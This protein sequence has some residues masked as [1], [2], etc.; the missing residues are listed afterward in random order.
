MTEMGILSGVNPTNYMIGQKLIEQNFSDQNKI[1]LSNHINNHPDQKKLACNNNQGY[2][3]SCANSFPLNSPSYIKHQQRTI[4]GLPGIEKPSKSRDIR[5]IN[6]EETFSN[7]IAANDPIS[8]QLLDINERPISDFFHNNMVPFYGAKLRQNMA[9]TGVASGSYT[10]GSNVP[11]NKTGINSGFDYSTPYKS[12]LSDYTGMSD[13]YMHKREAPPMFS[14]AEQQTGW[15]NGMPLFRP[16]IDQYTQSLGNIRNDLSPIES[17]KVGPGINLDPSI[18]AAGGFHDFTRILPN[19]VSDY[20]ANQLEGA[21]IAGKLYS[22]GL[23]TSYPGIGTSQDKVAPGI[24]KNK[25]DSFW[26]QTRRP[27]MTSKVGFQSNLD[28]NIPQ[29]DA[30]FRPNNATRDQTSYG[31]G[32]LAQNNNNNNNS[33]VNQEISIGQGPLGARISQTPARSETWMNIDNN[34]RSKSDCKSQPIGNPQKS[35]SGQGNIMAN[36]YVNETQRGTVNPQNVMQLNLTAE[37]QGSAFVMFDDEMKSTTKETTQY[38]YSG[39]IDSVSSQGQKIY[40]YIDEPSTTRA[41]MLEY[42]YA[43]NPARPD[44]APTNSWKYI[45][46]LPTTNKE[47]TQFSYSG[48]LLSIIPGEMSRFQYTG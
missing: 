26:D 45:D 40:T 2:N 19:N 15:I 24:T 37:K 23:P 18:S 21:V 22:A 7:F 33:C 9:G 6:K 16:D 13:T 30:S 36:Y 46:T 47:T 44:Q 34:I 42:S 12:T 25:P 20:K 5:K 17:I 48:D 28:Y 10:D 43:S 29:Y 38:S 1:Q 31:L 8:E 3:T 4:S 32:N 14:P 39:N 35:S 41:E 11:G 27:T